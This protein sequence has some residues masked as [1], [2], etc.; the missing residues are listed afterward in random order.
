MK[1]IVIRT[2]GRGHVSNTPPV[3][4]AAFETLAHMHEG[5]LETS[6]C[7][8]VE[9]NSIEEL[10]DMRMRTGEDLIVTAFGQ[11]APPQIEIYD[12]DREYL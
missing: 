10:V 5:R 11:A 8:T 7:W 1:F 12:A 3:A 4:S 9:L 2:S 6:G